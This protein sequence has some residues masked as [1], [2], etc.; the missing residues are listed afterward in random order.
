MAKITVGSGAHVAKIAV[1]SGANVAKIAV[2]IQ[3]KSNSS[4]DKEYS[5]PY[6][7]CNREML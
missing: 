1:G 4:L 3:D 6:Q 7:T 2:G 5:V